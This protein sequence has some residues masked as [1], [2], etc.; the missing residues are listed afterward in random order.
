MIIK[1]TS[2]ANILFSLAIFWSG[3]ILYLSLAN[4]DDIKIVELN[5]SDK[6]YHTACYF[7][8][9][10]LWFLFFHV[11][12]GQLATSKK[13]IV[14]GCLIL[15]GIII[16]ILQFVLTSYRTF[17]LWDALANAVGIFLASLFINAMLKRLIKK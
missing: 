15:F 4:I 5:A 11:K 8:L 9:G 13:L 1:P 17:D 6:L 16:E 3:L 10:V 7:I 14:A 2:K 12:Q